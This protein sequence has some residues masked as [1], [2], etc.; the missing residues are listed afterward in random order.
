MSSLF[1]SIVCFKDRDLPNTVRNMLR[2][3][4]D[5]DQITIGIILQEDE[6]FL[7]LFDDLHKIKNV[8]MK[9]Y[10][11]S[12]A[13]GCGKARAEAQR[14]YDGQDYFYQ[15]DSHMRFVPGWE[16][17]LIDELK[18]LPP[19]SIL[20]TLPPGFMPLTEVLDS[21][22][23]NEMVFKH[24][25]R[26]L[27][28]H[29]AKS[30]PLTRVP[31]TP[32]PTPFLAGGVLFAPGHICDME[33]DPY[34]YFH[35]EEFTMNLRLWTRGYTNYSPRFHFCWHSYRLPNSKH[36]VF[37]HEL[38][39][40]LDRF[41]HERSMSRYHMIAGLKNSS[42]LPADHL[43]EI[44]RYGLGSERS[45]KSW[46]ETYGMWLATESINPNIDQISRL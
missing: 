29:T 6:E 37:I 16:K 32:K 1:I 18:G 46:E 42:D 24:F 13:Q 34:F 27:P 3:A 15:S 31:S 22:S 7:H 4:A 11:S 26:N 33:F 45:V 39:P 38:D 36:S 9:M 44:E 5:P 40:A 30:Y 35:G 20:S 21:P 12:W 2:M 28:I 17:L 23:Y 43:I 10:P 25:F 14:L 19:K 8:K 41:L